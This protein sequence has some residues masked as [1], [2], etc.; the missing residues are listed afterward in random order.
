[1]SAAVFLK[2]GTILSTHWAGTDAL[3]ETVLTDADEMWLLNAETHDTHYGVE[4]APGTGEAEATLKPGELLERNVSTA[5]RLRVPVEIQKTDSNQ[6]HLHVSG[7]AQTLWLENGGRIVG[8]DDIVIRD[9]GVLWLQHQPGT[10]VAWLEAPITQGAQGVAGWFKSF[11]ESTV[12][13]P[14]SVVLKGKTQIL[15]F[16]PE[17][18]T[19][20]HVRTS[21]PVVT[22]YIVEGQPPRTEVHLQGANINL[23]APAGA[24]RLVLRAVGA[25]SLSG[26]ATVLATDTSNLTE[27]AGP[28]VL[29]APGSARM[30]SFELKQQSTVG[31]G[32]RASSDIVHSV[33][34]NDRGAVQAQGVVQ[35][36]DLLPGRYYLVIETPADT[37]PVQVQPIVFGLKTPDT[38]PPYEIL[39]RYVEGKDNDAL[40]YVPPQPGAASDAEATDESA[41][42]GKRR[43]AVRR[44]SEEEN[45]DESTASADDSESQPAEEADSGNN[46]SE[47]GTNEE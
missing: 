41:R 16:K 38:R 14:Q 6:L 21:V 42:P 12:K 25:D 40:L 15:N 26:V 43:R 22:H 17:R 27:G 20:L 11:H 31:I 28:E 45:T 2:R 33:L 13:P 19:M 10:L 46:E 37:A 35:M 39:R 5:G 18:T 32:V 30:F 44:T 9:S 34:Y 29:L 3:Q 36:P 7:N 23:F 4:I 47:P 1:M 8:G 24:S